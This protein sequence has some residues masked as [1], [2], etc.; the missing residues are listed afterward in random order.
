MDRIKMI[1][2]LIKTSRSMMETKLKIDDVAAL[3][4]RIDDLEAHVER[5]EPPAFLHPDAAREAWLPPEA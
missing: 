2:S 3:M 5:I 1:D 4:S